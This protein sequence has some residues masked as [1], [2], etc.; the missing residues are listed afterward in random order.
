M[1]TTKQSLTHRNPTFV[2]S[3]QVTEMARTH[4]KKVF[5][6]DI[7]VAVSSQILA[8][9]EYACGLILG[10]ALISN[11]SPNFEM[12]SKGWRPPWGYCGLSINP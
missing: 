4:L 11:E 8:I 5:S 10:F 7:G 3:C 1:P 6:P 9:Q 2:R 12:R